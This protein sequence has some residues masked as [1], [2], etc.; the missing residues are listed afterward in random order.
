M[1]RGR[2]VP[3]HPLHGVGDELVAGHVGRCPPRQHLLD[4]PADGQ[5]P[6]QVDDHL[7][8]VRQAQPGGAAEGRAEELAERAAGGQE[9]VPPVVALGHGPREQHGR[10]VELAGLVLVDRPRL[11]QPLAALLDKRL[12]VLRVEVVDLDRQ[13]PPHVVEEH[14]GDPLPHGR[15]GGRQSPV[16]RPPLLLGPAQLVQDRVADLQEAALLQVGRGNPPAPPEVAVEPIP[17]HLAEGLVR[18][19]LPLEPG[20]RVAGVRLEREGEGVEHP[21]GEDVVPQPVRPGADGRRVERAPQ[22]ADLDEVVEV[23]GLEGGV[24]AVVG[25]AEDLLRPVVQ[26]AGPQVP[27]GGQAEDRR[28]RTPALRPQG[29]ELAEVGQLAGVVRH[30]AAQAEPERGVDEV[31]PYRPLVVRRH[32][33]VGGHA[34]RDREVLLLR[35][36]HPRPEPRVVLDPLV[37]HPVEDGGLVVPGPRAVRAEVEVSRHPALVRP[38]GQVALPEDRRAARPVGRQ[39]DAVILL[40]AL[41]AEHQREQHLGL[42][43]AGDELLP[44]DRQ[45]PLGL[46]L[47]GGVHAVAAADELVEAE[48]E[49][50]A[51]GRR[52][53]LAGVAG[54]EAVPDRP[55]ADVGRHPGE[56]C[57]PVRGPARTADRR[58][59]CPDEAAVVRADGHPEGGL[60]PDGQRIGHEPGVVLGGVAVV[61]QAARERG[62]EGGIGQVPRRGH[63]PER[64]ADHVLGPDLGAEQLPGDGGHLPPLLGQCPGRAE[65]GRRAHA[66]EPR[67]RGRV[68]HPADQHGHVRPLPPAV[69]VQFV[70]HQELEPPGR[71][72]QL[73]VAGPG[74]DQLQ[75]HVVGEQDVGRLCQDRLPLVRPLLAGVPG[76]RDGAAAVG[77]P[78]AEELAEFAE[79]AVGQGVHGVDDDRA[80]ALAAAH[81]QDVVHDR[82]DVRQAL[83]RPGPRREHVRE[84]GPGDADRLGLVAV[85]AEPPPD[86]VGLGLDAEHVTAVGVQDAGR[87]QVVDRL[88]RLE[89]GVELDEGFGPEDAR[90]ELLVHEPAEGRLQDGDEAAGVGGVV[91]DHAPAEVEDVQGRAS[92]ELHRGE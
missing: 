29:R 58:R 38:V 5:Q 66:L 86:R 46:G 19:G 43:A 72:D 55:L 57:E 77:V 62:N 39:P 75:H 82:D 3:D 56:R 88:A 63:P 45:V 33:P 31:P 49:R 7:L 10:P 69:G 73:A 53:R 25:E 22:Q 70:E 87:N 20:R 21:L 26:A 2:P 60:D 65:G 83:A 64:L 61:P 11:D 41:P 79:L 34:Q 12:L 18:V 15:G 35:L 44:L 89:R 90:V 14:P 67:G 47:Q 4:D 32:P 28:G 68:P 74:Q 85:E 8:L 37:R 51:A 16:G 9:H 81:P 23:P 27:D 80:D 50:R 84:P 6:E 17:E 52:V 91:P 13:L 78:E 30:P 42:V 36:L 54:L 48:G 92:G 59:P 40:P 24:L 1:E 76:E 71:L